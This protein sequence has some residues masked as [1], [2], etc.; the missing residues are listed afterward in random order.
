M[1]GVDSSAPDPLFT[2][3]ASPYRR[4]SVPVS[5]E[6]AVRSRSVVARGTLTDD[7][8]LQQYKTVLAALQSSS[9]RDRAGVPEEHYAK[10]LAFVDRRESELHETAVADA[11]AA[12]SHSELH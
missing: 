10:L 3:P 12:A 5:S 11:A 8:R 2:R 6:S 7:Q 9:L 1:K 4:R